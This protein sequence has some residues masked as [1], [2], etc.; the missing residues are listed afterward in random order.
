MLQETVFKVEVRDHATTRHQ[1]IL[2]QD[3]PK[4]IRPILLAADILVIPDTFRRENQ[5]GPVFP[6]GTDDFIFDLRKMLKEHS[7]AIVIDPEQY[8]EIDLHSDKLR[9]PS[10][11]IT[12]VNGGVKVGHCSGG[13]K[14]SRAV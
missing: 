5:D 13:I 10:L 4:E 9:L 12:A 2:G 1:Q 11:H 14:L 8:L 6:S 3:I 7:V